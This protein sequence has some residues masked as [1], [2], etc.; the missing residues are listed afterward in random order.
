M[1]WER[2]LAHRAWPRPTLSTGIGAWVAAR[3]QMGEQHLILAN[4]TIVITPEIPPS[5]R[6][7]ECRLQGVNFAHTPTPSEPAMGC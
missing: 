3:L 7:S 6:C 2:A 4:M 1:T 5:K